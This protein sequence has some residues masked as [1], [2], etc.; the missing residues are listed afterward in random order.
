MTPPS[1]RLFEAALKVAD[2]FDIWFDAFDPADPFEVE[3]HNAL[4]EYRKIKDS[5]HHR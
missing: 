3:Q 1:M 4:E 2:L 5:L